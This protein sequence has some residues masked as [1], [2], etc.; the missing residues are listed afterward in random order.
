MQRDAAPDH[1]DVMQRA[2]AAAVHD[3]RAWP[4]LTLDP[5]VLPA[6]RHHHFAL[7]QRKGNRHLYLGEAELTVLHRSRDHISAAGQ[8][9]GGE[10]IVRIS[11]YLL[12]HAALDDLPLLH[13]EHLIC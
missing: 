4:A 5:D 10:Q 7:R 2:A 11:V 13:E 8:K 1:I 12:R 3:L 9:A 6:H